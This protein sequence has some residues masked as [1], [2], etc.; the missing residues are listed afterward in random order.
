MEYETKIILDEIIRKLERTETKIDRLRQLCGEKFT[1][2]QHKILDKVF[3][4]APEENEDDEE[5]EEEKE[6][7]IKMKK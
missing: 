6:R 2:E 3:G 5:T 1:E 4:E 7:E